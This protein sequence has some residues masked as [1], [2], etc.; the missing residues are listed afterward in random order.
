M[1]G[2]AV[3]MVVS[4]VVETA[5]T[6][7]ALTAVVGGEFLF[8][9]GL[10]VELVAGA[11]GL[12]AGGLVASALAPDAE[13]PKINSAAT[14]AAQGA[15]VN[16]SSNVE[17]LPVIYGSRIVGGSRVFA[18]ASGS[19]N[20][21]FHVVLVLGEG[22]IE[23]I[24]EIYLDGN[25]VGAL[26]ANGVATSGTYSGVVRVKKYLG[27]DEQLADPDLMAEIPDWT[28]SCR[29]RGVAYIYV[30]LTYNKD[31]FHGLPVI[32]A[33]V[34][35]RKLYDPRTGLT[36]FSSNP[37][38]MI[39]DYLT[40]SRYGRGVAESSIDD[41]TFIAAANSCDAPVALGSYSGPK[42]VSNGV[43]NVDSS[44]FDNL[45]TMLTSCRGMLIYSGGLFKLRLEEALSSTFDFTE[46]NITGGW[47]FGG[48]QKRALYNRA[49]LRFYDELNRYQP[50]ILPFINN[51][52]T[53]LDGGN[54]S[55]LA[56]E[57]PFTS[58][59]E[60]ANYIGIQEVRQSRFGLTASF[61]A[62]PEGLRTEVGDVVT[63]THSTPGW[64]NKPFRVLQMSPKSSD[65]VEVVVREY[66]PSVYVF[67]FAT[68]SRSTLVTN[69]PNP[70]AQPAAPGVPAIAEVQYQTT[71]SAGVKVKAVVSW[72][73]ADAPFIV[74]Y[75]LQWKLTSDTDWQ[76]T[77]TPAT[78][79]EL[80]DLAPNRWD[81]R[82]SAINALGK[83]SDW[84]GRTNVEILGLTAAP[85]DVANLTI[86]ASNGTALGQWDLSPDLDVRIGGRTVL[87]WTPMTTGA[88]WENGIPVGEFNGDAT[89]GQL[90]ML[91]GTYMAKFK[92]STGNWSTGIASWVLT[93]GTLTALPNS[94][95]LT[96]NTTWA[97][98]KSGLV[99]VGSSLQLDGSVPIDSMAALVDAWGMLDSLGGVNSAG[100]YDFAAVMDFGTVGTRRF[101]ANIQA[102]AFDTGDFIDF[103]GPVDDWDSVDGLAINDATVTL[104][105]ALSP[106]GVAY[107]AWFPFMAGDFTCRAAKFRLLYES[108]QPTHNVGVSQLSVTANW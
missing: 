71:G 108:A 22:E 104:L 33:A 46:D 102:L 29:L 10:A 88:H 56:L 23:S 101:T 59:M 34:K 7:W 98:S 74:G 97:G 31:A 55:E 30:R 39:R 49:K 4:S 81:F 15:L 32:T 70:T 20:E 73:S 53:A 27:S 95:T 64:I 41:A 65:E 68:P 63:I 61:T 14:Q 52:Y 107:S 1:A 92:D 58:K 24:D 44:A 94:Q 37:S 99:V 43:V 96:E 21:F 35:G 51:T 60:I 78:S 17:P 82:I 85:A 87:R 25:A 13:T 67:D 72:A 57:L 2:A 5:V 76:S 89:S 48:P 6:D 38:L 105:A 8:T 91:T 26:D 69:L 16:V 86:V 80:F 66:D 84:A 47:K 18:A 19:S 50:Q 90:P 28:S 45:K 93:A 11:A 83:S 36:A 42:Y 75:Q 79:Y 100:T 12:M 103:R 54:P 40:N 77:D 9:S 106:D 62:L 3:A